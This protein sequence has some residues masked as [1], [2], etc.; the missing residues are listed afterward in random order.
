MA[1]KF[2]FDFM[3][4]L[5]NYCQ[6]I[7]ANL[8]ILNINFRAVIEFLTKDCGVPGDIKQLLDAM[9]CGVGSSPSLLTVTHLSKL[10][11]WGKNIFKLVGVQLG[12]LPEQQQKM[13]R[14]NCFE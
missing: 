12:L 4:A 9:Y 7:T 5:I 8:P 14:K 3:Y 13:L 11:C 1:S 10:F 6:K 2:C